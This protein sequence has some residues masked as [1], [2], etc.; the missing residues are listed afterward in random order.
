MISYLEGKVKFKGSNNLTLLTGGVGYRVYA[1]IYI[2]NSIKTDTE[3]ALFIH[4][5]IREDCFDLYG[6]NQ[7]DELGLFEMLIEVSGI[8][9]KTALAIFNNGRGEKIKEAIIKGDTEFFVGVPRLGK[10]NAQKI[11]IELRGKLG[12]LDEFDLLGE[13]GGEMKEVMEALKSLGFGTLEIREVL[14]QIKDVN[15][16]ENK[17]K[18][19]IR[20]MGKG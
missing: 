9:P 14:K 3:C 19:A 4:S 16:V 2:I 20:R 15:G 6:F 17:I 7:S 8:G 1:P 11:I 12:S 10:K 18:E 13:G 5:H